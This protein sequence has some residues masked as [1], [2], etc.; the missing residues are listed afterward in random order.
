MHYLHKE[1]LEALKYSTPD[2]PFDLE[3]IITTVDVRQKLLLSF[4]ELEGGLRRLVDAGMVQQATPLHFFKATDSASP[5]PFSSFT[6]EDYSAAYEAYGAALKRAFEKT[7]D[8]PDDAFGSFIDCVLMFPSGG[9]SEEDLEEAE[10]LAELMEPMLPKNID[11]E[12]NGFE[13]G[14]GS[15]DVL[16]FGCGSN[17]DI[18]LT[19][20]AIA[21]VFR[22]FPKHPG[23][24][25]IRYYDAGKR[26]V[27]SDVST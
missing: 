18:E 1:I 7:K 20:D 22:A 14:A 2:D 3:R 17:A 24:H 27:V 25:I 10:R 23:S 21:P 16:I 15:I 13:G 4:D 9:Y 11:V 26:E 5:T 6:K 12:I 19:Y 8:G